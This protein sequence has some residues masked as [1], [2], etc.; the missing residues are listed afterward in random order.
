MLIERLKILYNVIFDL[1]ICKW[2]IS[3]S[4]EVQ[5]TS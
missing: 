4:W 1:A 3:V 5:W 2:P